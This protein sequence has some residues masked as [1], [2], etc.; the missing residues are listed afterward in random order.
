VGGGVLNAGGE[1][2]VGER[3]PDREE[4]P[5]AVGV[6]ADHEVGIEE[7]DSAGDNEGGS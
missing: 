5:D 1:K 2:A 4:L 6:L 3:E 7:H